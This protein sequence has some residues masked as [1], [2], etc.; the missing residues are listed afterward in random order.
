MRM[1]R[2]TALASL[3]LAAAIGAAA[4]GAH[5]QS[6]ENAFAD[7]IKRVNPE[8]SIRDD[9]ADRALRREVYRSTLSSEVREAREDWTTPFVYTW[10]IVRYASPAQTQGVRKCTCYLPESFSLSVGRPLTQ[11][12][13]YQLCYRQCF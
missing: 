3:V 13:I 5:A 8:N 10:G 6:A 2:L 1:S 9:Y 12:E 11:G 7:A 4:L